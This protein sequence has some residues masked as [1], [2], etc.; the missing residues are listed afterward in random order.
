MAPAKKSAA[1]KGTAKKG[2]AK[3]SAAKRGTAKKSAVKRGTAKKATA[4]KGTAKKAA[5]RG[6]ASSDNVVVASKV[7]DTV[8]GSGIRMSSEFTE[9]LN[10]EVHGLIS[11]AVQRAKGNGR[12]TV[13]PTDL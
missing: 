13:R 9:A 4:K 7:R 11:R 3:K 10:A 1:K 6:G 8:R 5:G 2:T 12:G